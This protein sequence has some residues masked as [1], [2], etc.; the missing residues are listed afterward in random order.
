MGEPSGSV[1]LSCRLKLR[2]YICGCLSSCTVASASSNS[3]VEG[4]NG[5]GTSSTTFTIIEL[6]LPKVS[7]VYISSIFIGGARNVP[8]STIVLRIFL[9]DAPE[10]REFQVSNITPA[11]FK[12][13]QVWYNGVR[14]IILQNASG[15]IYAPHAEV[16][17]PFNSTFT[18]AIVAR[19][20]VCVG[21]N[22]IKLDR[23][24]VNQ[25]FSR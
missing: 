4:T 1:G 11:S 2:S 16:E 15:F 10:R 5:A 23:A 6:V 8:H 9:V 22:D 7:G 17:I 18:G 3:A 25:N 20:I 13:L 24:I 14:K 21:N 19:K 12:Q